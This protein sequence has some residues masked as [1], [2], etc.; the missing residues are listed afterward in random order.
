MSRSGTPKFT[1]NDS[2]I[3][4]DWGL[5]AP[6][7]RIPSDHFSVRWTASQNFAAGNY[8]LAVKN[9]DGMRVL[10]DGKTF[11]SSWFDQGASTR[12]VTINLAGGLHSIEVD[13]YED[14]GFAYAGFSW[15]KQ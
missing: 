7:S 1:R 3:N 2:S 10:I 6:D 15:T 5:G 4:F 11:Y 13:Y 14:T 12:Y 9:D 8:K